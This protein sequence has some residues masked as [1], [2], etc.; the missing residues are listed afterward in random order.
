M[1]TCNSDLDANNITAVPLPEGS[2]GNQPGY[3]GNS[4][5]VYLRRRDKIFFQWEKSN[6][7]ISS[8]LQTV[9]TVHK[10]NS[11]TNNLEEQAR[12]W[13]IHLPGIY[14]AWITPSEIDLQSALQ[15][16]E[17]TETTQKTSW[18]H[19]SVRAEESE[20]GIEKLLRTWLN[21][22]IIN[23]EN[24]VFTDGMDSSFS[25]NLI[26]IIEIFGNTAI[27]VI[28]ETVKERHINVEVMEE[29]LRQLGYMENTRT[30]HSRL[31]VLIQSL[32]SP[33]PRVRD[34]VSIGLA[35]MDDRRALSAVRA[36]FERERHALIKDSLKMVVDQLQ[37]ALRRAS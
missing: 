9:T 11:V 8:D 26:L 24:E 13:K 5:L 1:N 10:E 35:A 14:S 25:R 17:F 28:E 32:K 3:A 37:A 19:G 33:D 7:G 36:A 16:A 31:N 30:R 27:R 6:S 22:L 12:H 18:E 20:S 23:A 4:K 15:R 21:K 29:L 34:A 2:S